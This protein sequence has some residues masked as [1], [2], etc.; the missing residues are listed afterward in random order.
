MSENKAVQVGAMPRPNGE[1]SQSQGFRIYDIDHKS[2]TIKGL[3]GGGR[4]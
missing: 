2:V 1:L 3:S 4:R